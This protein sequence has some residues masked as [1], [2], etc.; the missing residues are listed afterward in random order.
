MIL[1]SFVS[2]KSIRPGFNRLWKCGE[3]EFKTNNLIVKIQQVLTIFLDEIH[4]QILAIID[5]AE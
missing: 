1:F 2:T 5:L 3:Q 4:G